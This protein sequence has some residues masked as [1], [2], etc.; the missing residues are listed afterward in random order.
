[1]A[2]LSSGN[3][4]KTKKKK[5]K[6]VAVTFIVPLFNHLRETR[7]MLKTLEASLPAGI[8]Y[9]LIFVN[10]AST[11]GTAKWLAGHRNSLIRVITNRTNLGYAKSN[12]KAA[13]AAKGT[14]LC[15]LNNDLVF[16]LGGLEP[17]LEIL[18][19]KALGVGI[20]GNVQYRVVD[21]SLDHAGVAITPFGKIEHIQNL[22]DNCPAWMQVTAVT[23]ACLL[24]RKSDFVAAK[25]FDEAFIN[26]GEDM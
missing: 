8:S 22:A 25:G 23:G 15:L 10:D 3:F 24:I 12:N 7:V 6:P 14:L 19:D 20:V 2:H 1:M 17:M 16:G 21:G 18:K 5:R 9:E 4:S 26:G 11:D 13:K